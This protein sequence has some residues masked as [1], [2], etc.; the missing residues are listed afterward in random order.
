M[1]RHGF[2]LG[3]ARL[4]RQQAKITIRVRMLVYKKRKKHEASFEMKDPYFFIFGFQVKD[5]Q[6]TVRFLPHV[7]FVQQAALI[8]C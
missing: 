5:Q 3:S 8:S 6:R 7:H 4:R 2:V 1:L